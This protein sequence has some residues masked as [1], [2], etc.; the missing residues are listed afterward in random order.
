MKIPRLEIEIGKTM[1]ILRHEKRKLGKV[2]VRLK[3]LEIQIK[4]KRVKKA[5]I[6]ESIQI[7]EDLLAAIKASILEARK[8][9]RKSS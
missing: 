3:G 4:A 7:D 9:K 5:L 1:F 8:P 6:S 2:T